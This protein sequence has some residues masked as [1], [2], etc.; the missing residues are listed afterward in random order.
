MKI[1]ESKKVKKRFKLQ[2][3]QKKK[4]KKERERERRSKRVCSQDVGD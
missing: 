3:H 4:K 2:C 1:V